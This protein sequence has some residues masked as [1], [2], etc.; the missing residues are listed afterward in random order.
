VPFFLMPTLGGDCL[1]GYELYRFRDRNALLLKGEYR[2]AVHPMVDVAG[3]YEA[4]K[5]AP[6]VKGLGLRGAASS[7]GAGVRVHTATSGLMSLDIA[8][9]RD[10]Y[11]IAIGF[12]AGGS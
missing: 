1:M 3:V 12:T 10:G 11:N 9:G 2:W 6:A 4:G 7:V 8:R 5:V